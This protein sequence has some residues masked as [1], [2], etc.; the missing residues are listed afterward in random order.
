MKLS[1]VAAI[2]VG[3]LSFADVVAAQAGPG[4]TEA[5]PLQS[6]PSMTS[7]QSEAESVEGLQTLIQQVLA[8]VQKK[9][10]AQLSAIAQG[11]ILPGYQT[12]FPQVFGAEVGA[13]M[14]QVYEKSLPV[15][16]AKLK[17]QAEIYVKQGMTEISAT[18]IESPD[19]PSSDS[20]AIRT[21]VAMQ[22][23]VPLYSVAMGKRG[24]AN[25]SF[26]GTFVVVDGG[27]RYI[28]FQTIRG[29]DHPNFSNNPPEQSKDGPAATPTTIRIG[30]NVQGAKLVRQ[31]MPPYPKEAR[32]KHIQGTVVLHVVIGK[33]GSVA[34][35][36]VV[37]GPP[38]LANAAMDAV[39]QWRYQPTLLNG[40]PVRVDTTIS[41]V[42]KL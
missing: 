42:F 21:M 38:E 29:V 7:T 11:L 15:L 28:D 37:S 41:V 24:S 3:L 22:N 23:R 20:Y 1:S 19:Q 4:T 17:D 40:E 33:D 10:D 9:D 36:S 39:K 27:F 34:D 32:A 30:A 8:A 35:L 12:W 14:A 16:R 13:R 2:L 26:P 18:R 6:N 25:W 5:Q 31:V